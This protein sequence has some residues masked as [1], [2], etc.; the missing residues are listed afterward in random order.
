LGKTKPKI[1]NEFG[2][3]HSSVESLTKKILS[4]SRRSRFRRAEHENLAW[5]E[6]RRGATKL[7]S[8]RI[9]FSAVSPIWRAAD[10]IE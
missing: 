5:P 8:H 3:Q 9:G 4:D 1:A 7:A 6:A 2:V 10:R